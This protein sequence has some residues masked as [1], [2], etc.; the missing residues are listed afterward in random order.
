M[1]EPLL[2]TVL[3]PSARGRKG[4]WAGRRN[5]RSG[6]GRLGRAWSRLPALPQG[7]PEEARKGRAALSRHTR[8]CPEPLP[9]LAPVALPGTLR[10]AGGGEGSATFPLAAGRDPPGLTRSAEGPDPPGPRFPQDVSRAAGYRS[11]QLLPVRT[12]Q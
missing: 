4:G 11:H 8:S 5:R 2:L 12:L 6:G 9:Q 10:A 1:R 7:W 3:L